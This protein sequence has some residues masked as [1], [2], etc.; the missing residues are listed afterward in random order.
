MK[1]TQA[2]LTFWNACHTPGWAQKIT[3]S[4]M[5]HQP[6]KGELVNAAIN[7]RA[8]VG[9]DHLEVQNAVSVLKMVRRRL[10][11]NESIVTHMYKQA[12]ELSKI[13][14]KRAETYKRLIRR[15]RQAF[16]RT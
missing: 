11:A 2:D 6:S 7:Q 15:H 8:N 14:P 12:L 1:P 4:T 5:S 9:L 3:K 16:F 10:K 13:Q